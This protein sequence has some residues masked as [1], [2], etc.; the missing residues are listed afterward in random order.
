VLRAASAALAAVAA[1]ALALAEEQGLADPAAS[2][3]SRWGI[4]WWAAAFVVIAAL[5]FLVARQRGPEA[6]ARR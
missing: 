2:G 3:L 4:A 6:R 1:P 5:V